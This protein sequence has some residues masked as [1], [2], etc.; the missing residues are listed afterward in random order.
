M[1]T[2]LTA[3]KALIESWTAY[4]FVLDTNL[5][6][7]LSAAIRQAEAAPSPAA[8]QEPVTIVVGYGV[9]WFP[10]AG[11]VPDGSPLFTAPQSNAALE[12]DAERYKWLRYGDND[13]PLLE[14]NKHSNCGRDDAWLLR[15]EKLDAAIDAAMSAG[16]VKP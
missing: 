12:R 6:K 7:N 10:S 2:L 8:G 14:F 13:E 15:T 4:G 11:Y 9:Q 5:F 1:T 16:E 3:A